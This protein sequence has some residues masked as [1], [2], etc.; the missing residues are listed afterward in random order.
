[1]VSPRTIRRSRSPSPSPTRTITRP[2]FGSPTGS[3]T[4]N[5]ATSTATVVFDANATDADGTPANN[6]IAYS[7]GGADFALFNINSATGEVTFAA[8]PNFEAP[9]DAGGDNHL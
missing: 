5:E 7:L 1:M 8:V 2:L 6:T 3:A 9:A 4:V